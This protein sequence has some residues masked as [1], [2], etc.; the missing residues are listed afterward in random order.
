MNTTFLPFVS[1]PGPQGQTPPKEDPRETFLVLTI[2]AGWQQR[3]DIAVHFLLMQAAQLRADDMARRGYFSHT[4]PEGVTPNEVVRNLGY[5]LPDWYSA[6]GNNIESLYIGHDEPEEPVRS[7]FDSPKH[8][9][10]LVGEGFYRNQNALGV[11]TAIAQDGRSIWV[12]LSAP[13]MG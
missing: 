1:K 9:D 2:K 8:H 10:H 11:G 3:K 7:W 13:D 6:K 12:F 5:R 4:N